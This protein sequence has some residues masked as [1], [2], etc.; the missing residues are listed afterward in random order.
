MGR[1]IKSK[2]TGPEE[3]K[4]NGG[5]GAGFEIYRQ[6]LALCRQERKKLEVKRARVVKTAQ[7]RAVEPNDCPKKNDPTG[8]GVQSLKAISKKESPRSLLRV[9][10]SRRKGALQRGADGV[11]HR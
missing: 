11:V 5:I 4:M 1:E 7:S 8:A 10:G 6:A 2:G 3:A 9:Q